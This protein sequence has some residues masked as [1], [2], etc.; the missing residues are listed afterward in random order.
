MFDFLIFCKKIKKTPRVSHLAHS[1]EQA[2]RVAERLQAP[3]HQERLL[4]E[5]PLVVLPGGEDQPRPRRRGV[6]HDQR[7]ELQVGRGRAG[8]TSS[9][10]KEGLDAPPSFDK[11]HIRGRGVST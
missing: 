5:L 11:G 1:P 9:G 10:V 3:E 8:I 7:L 2:D 6:V 4:L